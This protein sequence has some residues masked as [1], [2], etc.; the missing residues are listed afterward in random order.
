V[1]WHQCARPPSSSAA[2]ATPQPSVKRRRD[3]A[4]QTIPGSAPA[5]APRNARPAVGSA[6]AAAAAAGAARTPAA[7]V[8]AQLVAA[9]GTPAGPQLDLPAD[10]TPPQLQEL[11]NTLLR[12]EE[13][14]PYAFYVADVELADELGPH[15][16]KSGASVEGV[17]RIVYQACAARSK[18]RESLRPEPAAALAWLL[19]RDAGAKRA[20][21]CRRALMCCSSRERRW[22]KA[23]IVAALTRQ[24]AACAAA[25]AV[26]SRA[27]H[28][29]LVSNLRPRRG[30]ALRLL[31]PRRCARLQ[32]RHRLPPLTRLGIRQAPCERQRRHDR[33]VLGLGPRGRRSAVC[34]SQELGHV[35]R[36]VA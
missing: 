29:L 3:G 27:R 21:A 32:Q 15:L 13:P 25:S 34:R 20:A 16:A 2:M 19:R 7:N 17:L 24:R 18:R 9:D 1:T 36:L 33:P 5:P 12:N 6:A 23:V 31:Q 14:T 8:I 11:L 35:R 10:V 26:P 28:A 30:G 4:G 22:R